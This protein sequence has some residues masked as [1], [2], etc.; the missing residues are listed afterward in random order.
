M[1]SRLVR[2]CIALAFTVACVLIYPATAL[3]IPSRA[4]EG[5][6]LSYMA[7]ALQHEPTAYR[8]L[9]A[10]AGAVLDGPEPMLPRL[11]RGC[12]ALAFTACVLAVACS[13]PTALLIPSRAASSVI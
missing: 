11:V 8:S 5:S 2:G 7:L 10:R 12:I 1:L 9:L 4:Y 13:Q 6:K 3:L